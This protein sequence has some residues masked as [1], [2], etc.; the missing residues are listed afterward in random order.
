MV[1]NPASATK[2]DLNRIFWAST[3]AGQ[4]T[5]SSPRQAQAE[6]YTVRKLP[7]ILSRRGEDRVSNEPA[8]LYLHLR[9]YS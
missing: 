1:G 7:A 6:T 9:P 4:L 5:P 8:G 2:Q 3:S